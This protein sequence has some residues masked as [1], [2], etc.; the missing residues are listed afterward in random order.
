M[1]SSVDGG[2]SPP[3]PSSPRRSLTPRR[4]AVS[5]EWR[6]AV[7]SSSTK[8]EVEEVSFLTKKEEVLPKERKEKEDAP[9]SKKEEDVGLSEL[10]EFESNDVLA[11]ELR[12]SRLWKAA[13]SPPV[14]SFLVMLYGVSWQTGFS[15][16][17]LLFVSLAMCVLANRIIQY[18]P[19]DDANSMAAELLQWI[20]LVM[21]VA[22]NLIH[23]IVYLVN[24][25]FS[26]LVVAVLTLLM[27]LNV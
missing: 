5:S 10:A 11:A 17:S 27:Q 20:M 26:A 4:A 7:P 13:C 19:F 18:V 6:T 25:R 3:A 1:M 24:P 21:N 8:R 15:F 23:D 16:A 14:L 12:N 2:S 9:A 22:G